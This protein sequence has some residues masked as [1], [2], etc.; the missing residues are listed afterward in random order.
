M[1][2]EDHRKK[3][4]ERAERIL[5][6]ADQPRFQMSIIVLIT[7]GAG[8]V[9]SYGLLHA[10]LNSMAIRYPLAIAFAYL[11][12]LALLRLWLRYQGVRFARKS[13]SMNVPDLD[14]GGI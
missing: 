14:L 12:F 9:A 13:N 2:R 8:F 7:G 1:V 4:I 3:L 5:Q 6:R 11:A 10:G